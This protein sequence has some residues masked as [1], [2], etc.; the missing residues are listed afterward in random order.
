VSEIFSMS[1][2]V[3]S[4]PSLKSLTVNDRI[5]EPPSVVGALHVVRT[6]P[7]V[8]VRA[9]T[10]ASGA[11]G[12]SSKVYLSDLSEVAPVEL[13]AVMAVT[14]NSTAAPLERPVMTVEVVVPLTLLVF[15]ELS[16]VT[17]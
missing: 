4:T 14:V 3:F 8:D 12:T 13:A 2:E 7:E 11:P 15:L 9:T 6:S 1:L 10:G 17:T 16:S 5:A